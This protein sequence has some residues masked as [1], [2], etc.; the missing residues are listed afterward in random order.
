[1][2]LIQNKGVVRISFA[3]DCQTFLHPSNPNEGY[4]WTFYPVVRVWYGDTFITVIFFVLIDFFY[5]FIASR[6]LNHYIKFYSAIESGLLIFHM[7]VNSAM[8]CSS[9]ILYTDSS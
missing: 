3:L 7:N 9:F 2:H 4:S 1:M 5:R 6:H 8:L